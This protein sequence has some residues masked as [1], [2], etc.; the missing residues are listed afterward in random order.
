ME[1]VAS[2][3]DKV[4]LCTGANSG[5]G[6]YYTKFMVQKG[7]RV[8][9]ACRSIEKGTLA[10][11]EISKEL[12][13]VAVEEKGDMIVMK[14]DL[15]SLA[16]VRGFSE[17]VTKR[18]ERIDVLCNNAGVMALETRELSEDGFEMQ[19]ASNHLGHFALTGLLLPLIE[20][21]PTG[22]IVNVSS[23]YHKKTRAGISF[24]DINFSGEKVA[25]ERWEAYA[26]SKLANILF[27]KELVKRLEKKGSH[28]MAVAAHPGMQLHHRD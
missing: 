23:F 27:T 2:Q 25:Y 13:D 9:M 21:S 5:L 20:K 12:K 28:V 22:R 4:V 26:Q 24:Q 17:E 6:W 15:S 14:L 11:E 18:F 10:A 1:S 19:L 7:A 8:I 3:K 16:S